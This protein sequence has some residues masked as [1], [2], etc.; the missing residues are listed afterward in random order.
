MFTLCHDYPLTVGVVS[1]GWNG[2]LQL[3]HPSSSD[4]IARLI[5]L[6]THLLQALVSSTHDDLL[7]PY[8]I[9]YMVNDLC[10][11]VLAGTAVGLRYR[12]LPACFG[13]RRWHLSR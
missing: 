13:Q 2:Q 6:V 5:A 8:T 9:R 11:A 12:R 1:T 10:A 4:W 7:A 3:A